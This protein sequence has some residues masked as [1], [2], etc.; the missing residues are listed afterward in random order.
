MRTYLFVAALLVACASSSKEGPPPA[1]PP[2]A[3]AAAQPGA[4]QQ[5]PVQVGKE[6]PKAEPADAGTP[7]AAE[8]QK[9]SPPAAPE[10]PL[11]ADQPF[12]AEEPKPLAVQ[13]HFEAPVPVQKKLK[14]GA[15]LLIVENHQIPLVAIDVRFLHG[16]DAD[17]ADRP[18]LAEFVA[19]TVD[20]GTKSRPAQKF[21]AEVE[22]LA[23]H[24]G[25]SASLETTTAH[26]NCLAETLDQALDLFADM[27]QNPAFRQE[28]VE[29]VRVLRLTGLEQKRANL[30]ALASDEADR[31]LFGPEH[32][33]GKPSG[34]TPESNAAITPAE[35]ADFHA[36]WWVPNNAVIS[37]SGDV[38]PAEIARLLNEKLASW[39][40]R[41]LPR[42]KLPAF[43]QLAK[44][45]IDALEKATATQSQVWVVGRLFKASDRDALPMRVANLPLGGMFTSRLNQNLREKH[46]YSYGVFSRVSLMRDSG[47]FVASG[48]IVAKNTVDAVAEYEGELKKFSSGEVSETELANAKEA[49]IRGIPSALE[50]NDAV[51]VAMG[52]LV[53]LGLPL[54]YYARLPGRITRVSQ[55]D[56]KRV[57]TKWLK[58]DR[59]PI[60][61]V[62]P[63]GQSKAALEKLGL[64]AVTIS[65]VPGAPPKT[66]AAR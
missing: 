42:L 62:G 50:S 14:N 4:Q 64:G 36:R 27:I 29:R 19:D 57:V 18:G 51:A 20:E 10:P 48:A 44:R 13:P 32:P 45:S 33:W 58:P 31:I 43:P 2:T 12:R 25:A 24:M 49:L 35:L 41:P 17:P 66:A 5:P 7:P 38:K 47:T 9:P 3:A 8:V 34:G 54:D 60:V 46:G 65:P 53:S 30:A 15:R 56:I 28:D 39:K 1:T 63:V 11:M 22:D 6:A 26:L 21:A 37:V 23:A 52:N 61:I 16:T 55:K 59:W 40:P